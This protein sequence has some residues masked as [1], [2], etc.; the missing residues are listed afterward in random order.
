MKQTIPPG[1]YVSVNV[2]RN[3][4]LDAFSI[5]VW[6]KSFS[7]NDLMSGC[8]LSKVLNTF[9]EYAICMR[10]SDPFRSDL[11]F[12]YSTNAQVSLVLFILQ[13]TNYLSLNCLHSLLKQ[14]AL[15]KQSSQCVVNLQG[16]SISDGSWHFLVV[17]FSNSSIVVFLDNIFIHQ[18]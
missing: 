13:M 14:S 10:S 18:R 12:Y 5:V 1:C 6:M 4:S 8:I 17:Q 16:N 2:D 7:N 11:L 9:L 3:I 15:P